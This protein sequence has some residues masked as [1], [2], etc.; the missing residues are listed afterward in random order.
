MKKVHW[1]HFISVTTFFTFWQLDIYWCAISKIIGAIDLTTHTA[2]TLWRCVGREVVGQLPSP[3][4]R[5]GDVER[6]ADQFID[7]N[8]ELRQ[9]LSV[10]Q[11]KHHL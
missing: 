3:S 7:V 2:Y 8:V 10:F 6:D 4:V 9:T 5:T 1:T 11:I